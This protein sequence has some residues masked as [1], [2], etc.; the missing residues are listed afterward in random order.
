VANQEP[1]I[2]EASISSIMAEFVYYSILEDGNELDI[3]GQARYVG[4]LFIVVL[5]YLTRLAFL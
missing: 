3:G 5:G 1:L 4:F 2:G